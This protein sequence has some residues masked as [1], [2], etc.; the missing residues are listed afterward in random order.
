V[1]SQRTLNIMFW[2]ALVMTP[3]VLAYTGWAYRV[4]RGKVTL[5][6]VQAH[7]KALY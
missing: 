5:A 4:M 1:S 7:G 2:V 3:I 6:Q